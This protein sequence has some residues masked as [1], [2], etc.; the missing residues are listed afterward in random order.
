MSSSAPSDSRS[1]N[2]LPSIIVRSASPLQPE[3]ED[4][5][6]KAA[7]QTI[8]A[9]SPTIS[10]SLQVPKAL[11]RKRSAS[12][13]DITSSEPAA[14]KIMAPKVSSKKDAESNSKKSNS[15]SSSKSKSKSK[16]T[17]DDWTEVTE[18]EERRRI[19]NKLAQRKFREKARENKER[20]ERE[21]RN[22]QHAGSCY[23]IPTPSD[24][25]SDQEVSGLPW[26]TF[27][28]RHVVSRGHEAESRR[29]SGRG[30]YLREDGRYQT[31][32]FMEHAPYPAATPS[33]QQ[34][35]GHGSFGGSSAGEDG[36]YYETDPQLF[37][38]SSGI[39]AQQ[40]QYPPPPQ[41]GHFVTDQF[42]ASTPWPES[43][44]FAANFSLAPLHA[45]ED[46]DQIYY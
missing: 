23:Q 16:S 9:P 7:T 37:Y 12:E 39:P 25:A 35:H 17:T 15:S 36:P 4:F 27:S 41:Q 18:P 24:V 20:A 34:H 13:A 26:G 10:S 46:T 6:S 29:S 33:Y 2:T 19:Q 45:S 44:P 1:Q 32:P 8:A 43:P 38:G 31:S 42:T 11:S 30:D 22:Q 21:A 5:L 28:M 40:S 3:P 14:R